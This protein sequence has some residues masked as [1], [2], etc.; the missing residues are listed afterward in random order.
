MIYF[1][2]I[3]SALPSAKILRH[4]NKTRAESEKLSSQLFSGMDSKFFTN[5][6]FKGIRHHFD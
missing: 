6:Q 2:P 3:I 1:E 5:C 4:K